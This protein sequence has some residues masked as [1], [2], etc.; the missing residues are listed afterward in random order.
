MPSTI[1]IINRSPLDITLSY[2]EEG[3]DPQPIGTI[4]LNQQLQID[5]FLGHVF[6][7]TESLNGDILDY[8]IVHD[9]DGEYEVLDRRYIPIEV[10]KR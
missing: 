2:I 3:F 9:Y 7:V 1:T 5:S 4:A 8:L 10:I 6:L